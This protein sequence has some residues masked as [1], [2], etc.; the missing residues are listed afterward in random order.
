MRAALAPGSAAED[1]RA[2]AARRTPLEGVEKSLPAPATVRT[3][4]SGTPACFAS[5]RAPSRRITSSTWLND[6]G[7]DEVYVSQLGADQAGFFS[8][9]RR[10]LTPRLSAEGCP[11]QRA[12]GSVAVSS[13]S[14]GDRP[15]KGSPYQTQP[16]TATATPAA[17][18]A[19]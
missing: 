6:A 7:F 16:N 14:A 12:P 2:A 11:G 17:S 10:G 9:D 19:S 4:R 15:T 8:F 1:G 5:S 13:L 3:R 18:S